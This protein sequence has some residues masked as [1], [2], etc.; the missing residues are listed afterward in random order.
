LELAEWIASAEHPLT[1]RVM[2][3]RI[4]HHVFGVGILRTTDNFGD[5]GERP[6]HPQLLDYLAAEFVA[7][8]WSV[9][10]MV[11]RMVLS[12]AYQMSYTPNEQYDG[13]DIENRLLWRANRKR[14]EAECIRDAMLTVSGQL[15]P[16]RGGMTIS[17]LSQYDLGYKHDSMRRSVYVPAFR[18]S[19]MG[20]LDVF[21]VANPNLVTGT[22]NASTLPTQSLYLMN[23]PFVIE[24]AKKAAER[25]I[26]D[27]LPNDQL[28]TE[29]YR[30][31]LGR[32]P[33]KNEQVLAED[34][35]AS[36][37]KDNR[38]GALTSLCHSVFASV[39]FRYVY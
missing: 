22:R 34:Y 13:L 5:S 29:I 1:A 9:K 30:L 32:K 10:K 24:Q 28:V 12:S 3:N 21:D 39:D 8:G 14:L 25:L 35:L 31:A 16:M 20:I 23:S 37:P 7:D 6:S 27:E 36:F 26:S 38:L 19:L 2:V 11:R 4:W 18:N 17:K 33:T 15:D